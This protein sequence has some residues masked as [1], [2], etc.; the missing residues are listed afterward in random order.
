MTSF[1]RAAK[2]PAGLLELE[3]GVRVIRLALAAA[4]ALCATTAWAQPRRAPPRPAEP[5]MSAMLRDAQNYTVKVRSTVIWPIGSDR[6]GTGQGTGFF[7]DKSRGWILTNAHVA[8]SSPAVVEVA[9]GDAETVWLPVE[10]IYVDN[11][12]DIAVLRLPQENVPPTATEAK[13]GCDQKVDQGSA[14]V[15]YGHPRELNF[16]ATRGI[17]SSIRTLGNQEYVQMDASLNPGN[18]GGALLSVG[19]GKVIGI[20][21]ASVL[22]AGL[23]LAIPVRHA[24]PIVA[25]LKIGGDPTVPTLPVYW[26]RSGNSETLT[27]ARTFPN[28]P[29]NFSLKGG[30]VVLGVAGGARTDSLPDLL[31]AL[32]GRKNSVRFAVRRNGSEIEVDVPIT[33][34]RPPL[35]REAVVFSGMLIAERDMADAEASTMPLLEIEHVKRGEGAERAG[36]RAGDLLDDVDGRRF[37]SVR[38]LHAWLSGR[39]E[40]ESVKILVRREAFASTR[41]IGAEY[42]RLEI[43]LRDET[44]LQARR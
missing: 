30:D 28:A 29:A 2:F 25:A 15:A 9:F 32:R 1:S 21:T 31:S 3:C 20:S 40:G 17:V 16:T 39:T 8:Q 14:V 12:L 27:V 19:A 13:L 34:S 42:L 33:P 4:I 38:D 44:L 37:D 43:V 24:C 35:S 5:D 41:R 11:H 22:G 18:S 10:R 36:L 23:G 26:L 7:I 6:F